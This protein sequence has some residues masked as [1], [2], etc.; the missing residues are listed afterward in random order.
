MIRTSD[1]KLISYHDDPVVQLFD[2]KSD[3]QETRNL[4]EA[5]S[6][7]ATT[8]ALLKQLDDYEASLDKAPRPAKK[9]P[10]RG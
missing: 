2:M 4:A 5:P 7:A 6:H 8:R 10:Q 3:P 1:Y 9:G